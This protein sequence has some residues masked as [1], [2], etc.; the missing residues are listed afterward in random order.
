MI[1][2]VANTASNIAPDSIRA[3]A[4]GTRYRCF[5]EFLTHDL[6]K[7]RRPTLDD[8]ADD[9]LFRRP[10]GAQRSSDNLKSGGLAKI[11]KDE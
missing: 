7:A 11:W 9:L 8:I 6:S 1:K 4:S 5:F 2:T 3:F 10:F